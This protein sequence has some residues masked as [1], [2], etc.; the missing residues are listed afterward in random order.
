MYFLLWPIF[1]L[2]FPYKIIGKE[3]LKGHKGG[4]VICANHISFLDPVYIA[5][6]ITFRTRLRFMAK[7]ELFHNKFLSWVFKGVGAFPIHRGVGTA[8]LKTAEEALKNGQPLVIFP[9]G[10][11]SKDGKLGKAKAG[12]A[13][14]VNAFDTYV[15][16]ITLICKNQQVRPFRKMTLVV[17]SPVT[18]PTLAEGTSQRNHLRECTAV[19]MKPIEEGLAQ[20][21]NKN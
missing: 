5:F 1:H 9:E 8:G 19:L 7:E 20:Y 21:G 4:F 13:M 3:N 18:M 16:P 14:L 15:L 11:R 2:L 17:S 10:T 12:A 6:A